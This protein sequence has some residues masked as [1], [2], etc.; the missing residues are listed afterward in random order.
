MA[1]LRVLY[2]PCAS[3]AT[4]IIAAIGSMARRAGDVVFDSH[5][6]A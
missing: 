5:A 3:F 1:L 6:A 2:L 4:V